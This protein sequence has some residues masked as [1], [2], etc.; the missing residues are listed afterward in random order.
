MSNIFESM[1]DEQ[2]NDFV[3]RAMDCKT[4]ADVTALAKEYGKEI[5][6]EQAEKIL[7]EINNLEVELSDEQLEKVAGGWSCHKGH[8]LCLTDANEWF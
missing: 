8:G 7:S 1:S 4:A 6:A 2:K 3:K 5:S